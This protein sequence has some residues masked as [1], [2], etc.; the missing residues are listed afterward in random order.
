MNNADPSPKAEVF[1]RA[2]KSV[3]RPMMRMLISKGIAA[4]AFYRLVKQTF[5]E[6]AV[7]MMGQD[8][9]D[10]RVS[11][12]TG[13]HRR[14]VKEFRDPDRSAEETL[15][16][17][18]STLS[19]VV[20]RWLSDPNY[21]QA[22]GAPRPV[23]RSGDAP[24]FEALVQS[25]SRDVRPRTVLD[26]LLRQDIVRTDGDAV[27]L[28]LDALVG[29]ADTDQ[30][31]HFFAH[32][33]GDHMAAAV[34]NLLAEKPVLLER[35]VFYNHLTEDSV[36]DI[37]RHVRRLSQDALLQVNK[38]AAERQSEDKSKET[39]THRFRFG[40]FFYKE[41]EDDKGPDHP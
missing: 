23:P 12:M 30:R 11:V 27:V 6:T 26:E 5:V 33:V 14:D 19:S 38:V 32:N 25:V 17:K 28:D 20:G 22:D 8:A 7:E 29:P 21:A 40:M 1:E 18:V 31:M 24:S 10:S 2:L 35:A 34:E 16:T 15:R 4:P 41:D 9:T 3:L 13:V 36:R 37:E 39:G